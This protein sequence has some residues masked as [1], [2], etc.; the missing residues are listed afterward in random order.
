[1]VHPT[2]QKNTGEG[3]SAKKRK[4]LSEPPPMRR[5]SQQQ[6][7]NFKKQC[8]L[9]GE[10]CLEKDSRHPERWDKAC[11]CETNDIP[12]QLTF[13][14]QLLDIGEGRGDEWARD[15]ELRLAGVSD[16]MEN[17]IEVAIMHTENL[18]SKQ[19]TVHI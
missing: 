17:T 7:F 8:I 18:F 6:E 14:Q 1:M 12:G 13:K 16:L 2:Y 5:R 10:V 11:Q 9:C 19:K 4:T 15:V 3:K